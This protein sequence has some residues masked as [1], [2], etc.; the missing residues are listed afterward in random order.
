MWYAL[1][2]LLTIMRRTYF[3]ENR[4]KRQCA[5]KYIK[6]TLELPDSRTIEFLY[7]KGG[8][9]PLMLTS[10]PTI[11]GIHFQDKTFFS[12]GP[13]VIPSYPSMFRLI[14]IFATILH[15]IIMWTN[16][17]NVELWSFSL[18]HAAY[19]CNHLTFFNS[20]IAPL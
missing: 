7:N 8:D 6:D 4:N 13:L 14:K 11:S 2:V 10:D 9:I 1:S 5:I 12:R 17:A 18:E 3:Q 15:A 16:T 19:L 20:Q